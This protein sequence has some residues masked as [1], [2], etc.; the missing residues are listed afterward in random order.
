MTKKLTTLIT[1]PADDYDAAGWL[2]FYEANPGFRRSVGAAGV[3]DEGGEGGDDNP[4]ADPPA[5]GDDNPPA[6]PPAGDDNPPADPPAGEGDDGQ[7]DDEKAG[8][9]KDLMKHKTRAK[10]FEAKLKKLEGVD[11]EEYRTLK[12]QREEAERKKLEDKGEYERITSQMVEQ[13]EQ[14]LEALRSE[15]STKDQEIAALRAQVNEL[16]VGSN[17][18]NSTFLREKLA[19]P[20]RYARRDF[21]GHFD[22]EDGSV[23]AYD[24]PRGAD[25]RTPLVD[26][27]GKPLGFDAAIEKL[28][29]NS[30]D[31]KDL[32]KASIKPGAQSNPGERKPNTPPPAP[33]SSMEGIKA[34]IGK[35]LDEA[36]KTTPN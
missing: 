21:E 28:I 23:V 3:N 35:L 20:M 26:G 34:G 36:K 33:Q 14:E 9:I 18:D 24:K 11:V 30:P 6:D 32:L 16:T 10:E 5:G 7:I 19:V 27:K 29:T 25:D 12:Q 4:P 17:F 1:P 8:L 13:H 2:A 31:A 22:Y 15:H